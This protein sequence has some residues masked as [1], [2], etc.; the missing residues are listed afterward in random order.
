MKNESETEFDVQSYEEVW[1]Q[2]TKGEEVRLTQELSTTGL[3]DTGVQTNLA[4]LSLLRKLNFS[5]EKMIK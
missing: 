2:L 5:Q 4:G 3:A 1:L